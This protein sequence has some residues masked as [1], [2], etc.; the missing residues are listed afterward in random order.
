MSL[1][2]NLDILPPSALVQIIVDTF[3]YMALKTLYGNAL[4][5]EELIE[6]NSAASFFLILLVITAIKR[7]LGPLQPDNLDI[8]EHIEDVTRRELNEIPAETRRQDL[9]F[10]IRYGPHPPT[11]DAIRT[12][13]SDWYPFDL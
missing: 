11:F 3:Q 12:I 1:S 13:I 9:H 7:R 10:F 6:T 2:A 8:L 4:G 5:L